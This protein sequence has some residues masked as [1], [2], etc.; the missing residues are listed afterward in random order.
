MSATTTVPAASML[1]VTADFANY[2]RGDAITNSETIAWCL[3][4]VS[5]FTS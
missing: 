5:G 1:I 2:H 3:P 4:P